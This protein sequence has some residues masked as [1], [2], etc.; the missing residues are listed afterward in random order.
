MI[1]RLASAI[2]ILLSTFALTA[3]TAN[4]HGGGLDSHGCH[5]DRRNGV[6]HC[7]QRP[8]AEQYIASKEEMLTVPEALNQGTF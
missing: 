2:L 3:V 8:R 5:Q 6:Y 1:S 4:A 7:L